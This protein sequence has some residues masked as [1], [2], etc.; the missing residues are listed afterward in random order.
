MKYL[1]IILA[2]ASCTTQRKAENWMNNHR[3]SAAAYY[4]R[5]FPI[6]DSVVTVIVHDTAARDSAVNSFQPITDSLLQVAED[7]NQ[8]L[9]E[10]ENE[11]TRMQKEKDFTDGAVEKLQK[12]LASIKRIDTSALR[13][14]ITAELLAK[15][16]IP[17]T[18]KTDH[19]QES[20]AK[21]LYT[22][23]LETYRW[24][25]ESDRKSIGKVFGWFLGLL[26]RQW[27]FWL[28]IAAVIGWAYWRIRAG[29]LKS[30]LS[31]FK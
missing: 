2:F 29:A 30:V 9:N 10:A 6:I 18:T 3:D 8:A 31:K 15:I 20:S 11:L 1:I 13:K 14:R 23:N 27:W 5:T 7:R 19:F 28:L 21:A 17:T 16:P 26:I 22:K 24:N 12:Q 4:T 25:M